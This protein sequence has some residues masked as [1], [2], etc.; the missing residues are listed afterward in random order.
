MQLSP[1]EREKYGVI[2]DF[3]NGQARWFPGSDGVKKATEYADR[4]ELK[5]RTISSPRTIYRDLQGRRDSR[6]TKD[7]S[8]TGEVGVY[9]PE[10]RFLGLLHRADLLDD[11]V[12]RA[13]R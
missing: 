8:D 5:I 7:G 11:S 4:E 10:V 13:S 12:R 9:L 3:S 1:D 2:V 6:R